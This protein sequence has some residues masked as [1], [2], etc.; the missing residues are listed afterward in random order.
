MSRPVRATDGGRR[1]RD[2]T[3]RS[4]R[5]ATLTVGSACLGVVAHVTAG[6]ALPSADVMLLIAAAVALASAGLTRRERN[7]PTMLAALALVQLGIHVALPMG[8]EHVHMAATTAT[9]AT[10][11]TDTPLL[12]PAMLVAHLGAVLALAWWLRRGE[13]AAWR[14]LGEVWGRLVQPRV[15]SRA[16]SDSLQ[17]LPPAPSSI[18]CGRAPAG[19][20]TV[21]G[22]PLLSPS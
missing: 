21:R 13:T 15:V 14:V 11:A 19:A 5:T 9:T 12:T 3:R 1:T 8:H 16:S 6:G 17:L 22:P 7:L 4:L 2:S 20:I 18:G 10:A